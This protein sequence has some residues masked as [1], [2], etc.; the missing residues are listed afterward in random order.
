MQPSCCDFLVAVSG[1]LGLKL[2]VLVVPIASCSS[3]K[4][5]IYL[6]LQRLLARVHR[7]LKALI[8]GQG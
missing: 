8:I 1:K 3:L 4:K 7:Y 2:R 6:F 5:I